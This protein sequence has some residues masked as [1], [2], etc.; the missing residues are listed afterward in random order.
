MI[1]TNKK[2]INSKINLLQKH[3]KKEGKES[4]SGNEDTP[5]TLDLANPTRRF[6]LESEIRSEEAWFLVPIIGG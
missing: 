4:K 2:K 3:N 6:F 5:I 1:W